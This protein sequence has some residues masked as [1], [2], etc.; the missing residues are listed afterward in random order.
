MDAL[1]LALRCSSLLLRSTKDVATH[2][3]SDADSLPRETSSASF[4]PNDTDLNESDKE[5]HFKGWC[6]HFFL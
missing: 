1:E 6:F 2:D 3:A 4:H 5:N